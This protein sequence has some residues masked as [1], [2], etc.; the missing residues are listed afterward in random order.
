MTHEVFISYSHKDKPIAD[1][2]CANLE[3]AGIRCWIAPRDISPGVDWPEAISNA[4]AASRVLVLIFSGNSNSSKDVGRELILASNNNLI[5]LPFKID[6]IAPEPGKQYYLAR[7]HWLDAMNPPTQEQ[8]DKLV[9]YVKSFMSVDATGITTGP[10]PTTHPTSIP[11]GSINSLPAAKNRIGRWIAGVSALI[12]L[13]AAILAI[14]WS[15]RFDLPVLSSLFK[16]PAQ[17][18]T[19]TQQPASSPLRSPTPTSTS[20][21]LTPTSTPTPTLTPTG[22][23]DPRVKNPSNQHLYLLVKT[24]QFWPDAKNTC[25]SWGGHLA[26][27]QD[28]NENLFLYRLWSEVPCCAFLGATDEVEEGKWVWVTGEPWKWFVWDKNEPGNRY[29]P[30]YDTAA[31]YLTFSDNDNSQD[32]SWS[33]YYNEKMDFICEWEPSSP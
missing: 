7:T 13:C 17:T 29:T 21:P 24:P 19:T 8:I 2:I 9:D 11:P 3:T 20:I 18:I 12:V 5:I 27:V 16:T 30:G 33:D 1:A 32:L 31:N 4:I 23:P 22:T 25:A 14:L 10:V 15:R 26:T 28:Y 6:D